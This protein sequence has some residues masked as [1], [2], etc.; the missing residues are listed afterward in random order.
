MSQT[1][2][3]NLSTQS[4]VRDD[5]R[6]SEDCLGPFA[7]AAEA[8]DSPAILVEYA[9]TW[10]E[11]EESAPYREMAAELDDDVDRI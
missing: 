2:W 9:R 7:T 8:E 1:Y 10:L 4:V 6:P 3:Y 5:E 11:S